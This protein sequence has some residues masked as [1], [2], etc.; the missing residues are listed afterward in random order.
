M[1]AI[2]TR[3]MTEFVGAEVVG[4]DADRLLNDHDL[5]AACTE[6]LEEYG[7]L[8]FRELN[9]D[10]HVQVAFGRNLGDLVKFTNYPIPEVMEISFDPANPNAR[11]FPSNDYWHFDGSMDD[12]P[13]KAVLMSARV[14]AQEGGETEFASTYAAYDAL[15]DEEKERYVGLRVIH[16][17]EAIQRRTY[18]DPTPEQLADWASWPSREHPLV[19]EHQSGRHSLVFGASASHIVGMDVDEG[20]ALLADL[21]RR[22]TAPDRVLRHT[23]SVGDM[24]IWNNL[25]LVHRACAFDRSE[26]RRMHRT[27]LA[28]DEP[29]K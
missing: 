27:T 9:I 23:W 21:A 19:W 20:K 11:Y 13:A 14:I 5:P 26:P 1:A 7:V 8:L 29:I 15:S 17:F 22:S 24:V 28:G 12:I 2:M 3:K 25:G 16:T 10:D 4:V 18:A 6:A